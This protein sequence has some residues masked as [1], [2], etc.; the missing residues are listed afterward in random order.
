ME[1]I[2]AT[3]EQVRRA[4]PDVFLNT[5]SYPI[6]GTHYFDA[7][8]LRVVSPKAWAGS[9]DRDFQIRGRHSRRFYHFADQ[10]LRSEVELGRLVRYDQHSAGNGKDPLPISDSPDVADL[11]RRIT[12]A[13][14]G[15]QASYAEAEA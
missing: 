13:R 15:L 2:E 10:L 3:I 14:H 5:V 7:V 12:E 8:A 9:S 1:D 11:R 4:D 6:K